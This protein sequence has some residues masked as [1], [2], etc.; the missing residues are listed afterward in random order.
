MNANTFAQHI[1][2]ST[3]I[4]AASD[5]GGG[6]LSSAT[7]ADSNSDQLPFV[8]VSDGPEHAVLTAQVQHGHLCMEQLQQRR[9]KQHSTHYYQ[10]YSPT[11]SKTDDEGLIT[12]QN[13]NASQSTTQAT[14]PHPLSTVRFRDHADG[15]MNADTQASS[16]GAS[17]I[18]DQAVTSTLAFRIHHS[19]GDGRTEA[20][21]CQS[22]THDHGL[23]TDGMAESAA[24]KESVIEK[25]PAEIRNRILEL[26]LVRD[27]HIELNETHWPAIL[28][29]CKRLRQEGTP[30]YLGNNTFFAHITKKGD[31]ALAHWLD[32]L[33][34]LPQ[35]WIGLVRSITFVFVDTDYRSAKPNALLPPQAQR[36]WKYRPRI[37]ECRLTISE[38][39]P[40]FEYFN[41]LIAKIRSAGLTAQQLVWPG[42]CVAEEFSLLQ[43]RHSA[44]RAILN[45]YILPFLLN[46]HGL[47][48]PQRPPRDVVWQLAH[49]W[50]DLVMADKSYKDLIAYL[51][52]GHLRDNISVRQLSDT[53]P[54][55]RPE[56]WYQWWA[57]SRTQR[58]AL[59]TRWALEY[60]YC[61]FDR[62]RKAIHAA[63]RPSEH[64]DD[65]LP[66]LRPCST[67]PCFLLRPK[68][69]LEEQA[70]DSEGE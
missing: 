7:M 6:S 62:V 8:G 41:S 11:N 45:E 36:A 48:D 52:L 43:L 20:Q 30:I 57:A 29:T 59:K 4:M 9:G 24:H 3:T 19:N 66:L 33:H 35:R 65:L 51:F 32:I 55:L 40:W 15:I 25:I 44:D 22:K 38:C 34:G 54:S 14:S 67:G 42:I 1:A 16:S 28:G 70:T 56:R 50:K 58:Q 10:K 12:G 27:E 39:M 49:E 26:A 37:I 23:I 69:D 61:S 31:K 17:A 63:Q 47:Y 46:R 21:M 18:I 13:T 60:G 5:G 68:A 64:G 53:D 2:P